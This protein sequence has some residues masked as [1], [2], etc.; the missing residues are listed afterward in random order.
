M[1]AFVFDYLTAADSFF[2]GYIAFVLIALLGCWLTG[3]RAFSNCG[4]SLPFS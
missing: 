2:W 3:K 1:F 4:L